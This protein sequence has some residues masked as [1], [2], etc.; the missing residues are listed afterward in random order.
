MKYKVEVT[1]TYVQQHIVEAD[2]ISHALEIA[3][4]ISSEMEANRETY[5]DSSWEAAPVSKDEKTT[6]TPQQQYLK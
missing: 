6:Y 4:E 2:D 3:S 1:K 5:F